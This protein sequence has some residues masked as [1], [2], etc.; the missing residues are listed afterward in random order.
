[1]TKTENGDEEDKIDFFDLS[2]S[3]VNAIIDVVLD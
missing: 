2:M 1:M 3:K